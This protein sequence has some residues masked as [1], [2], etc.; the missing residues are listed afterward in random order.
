VPDYA[1]FRGALG[2]LPCPLAWLDLDALEAN[3]RDLLRRAGGQPVRLATKSL[4]CVPVLRHVQRMDAR[5]GRLMCYHPMEAVWLAGLGFGDLLVAYPT[6]EPR[7]LDAVAGAVAEGADIRLMTDGPEQLRAAQ[8]AAERAG[9]RLAVWMDLDCSTPLPGLWF[10]VQRSPLRGPADWDPYLAALEGADRLYLDGVMGYEAQIAGVGD[11]VPG[12]ALR[13]AL[14]RGLKAWSRPRVAERRARL[15]EHLGRRGHR[16]RNVNAGGTGSLESSA[17]EAAVTEVAAGSGLY[18]PTLFDAYRR[19]SPRPAAGFALR[20]ARAPQPG[21]VTCFGGGYVASG[22]AGVDKVPR[23]WLPEG[24]RLLPNEQ[25]GEV[26]TP[27]RDPSGRLRPGDPVFFRHAKAGELCA[28]FPE[29]QVLR[30][31]ERIGTW[32]TYRG[33]GPWLLG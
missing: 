31:A 9:T 2:E 22:P 1:R 27:L 17:A 25:A 12:Q 21:T 28:R 26:Q 10:G 5:F 29:L 24:L 14:I 32:P 20:V 23:P 6:V 18:G 4:R 13:S 3:A 15:L 19:F 16:P 11:A 30:G 33:E 8:A 7:W